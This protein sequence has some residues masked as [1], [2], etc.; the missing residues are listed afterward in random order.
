VTNLD[1]ELY[2]NDKL[3]NVVL[4]RPDHIPK[5]VEEFNQWMRE[6]KVQVQE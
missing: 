5:I 4:L 1:W 3:R 6:T 2:K